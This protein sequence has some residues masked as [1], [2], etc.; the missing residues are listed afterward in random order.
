MAT[1][2]FAEMG[3]GTSRP[4]EIALL[5]ILLTMTATFGA[6][7][8]WAAKGEGLRWT[9]V[10]TALSFVAGVAAMLAIAHFSPGI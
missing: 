4:R 8:V 3:A 2:V 10:E 5:A 9:L 6:L 1:S 7:T